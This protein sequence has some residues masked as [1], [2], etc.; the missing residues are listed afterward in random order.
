[1]SVCFGL[2]FGCLPNL[3]EP[4]SAGGVRMRGRR[5]CSTMCSSVLFLSLSLCS[6]RC[7]NNGFPFF[8]ALPPLPFSFSLLQ[9]PHDFF[10]RPL[11]APNPLFFLERTSWILWDPKP[12]VAKDLC[13]YNLPWSGGG[14]NNFQSLAP[15]KCPPVLLDSGIVET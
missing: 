2:C 9:F 8:G 13:Q 1:M 5:T 15:W 7:C 11:S 10:C 4:A 6:R 3:R 14:K 12:T